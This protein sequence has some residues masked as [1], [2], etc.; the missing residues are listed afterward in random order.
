MFKG[1]LKSLTL[2]KHVFPR[3]NL[4]TLIKTISLIMASAEKQF[5]PQIRVK[6]KNHVYQC[7]FCRPGQHRQNP[8]G[9]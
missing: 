5:P 1:G 3:Q 7:F 8:N 9:I 4:K 6:Q 2:F